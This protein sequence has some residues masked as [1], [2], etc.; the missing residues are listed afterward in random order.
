MRPGETSVRH[1]RGRTPWEDPVG[2]PT[3]LPARADLQGGEGWGGP[4]LLGPRGLKLTEHPE[5]SRPC[6]WRLV[7]HSRSCSGCADGPREAE[8]QPRGPCD[9]GERV[10]DHQTP[11]PSPPPSLCCLAAADV[12]AC[13]EVPEW[14]S[15]RGHSLPVPPALTHT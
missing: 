14:A 10:R 5:A 6:R 9:G 1:G 2:G 4:D 13:R 12:W 7:E 11:Q 3:D 15:E 8:V